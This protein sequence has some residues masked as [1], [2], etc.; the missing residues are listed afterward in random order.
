MMPFLLGNITSS[1]SPRLGSSS[2]RLSR[3]S[4]L[5]PSCSR[6]IPRR[7]C[8][9]SITT[10]AATRRSTIVLAALTTGATRYI[11]LFGLTLVDIFALALVLVDHLSL[12]LSLLVLG[13]DGTLFRGHGFIVATV[14][15]VFV[16]VVVVSD[17]SCSTE[18]RNPQEIP[19]HL[20]EIPAGLILGL[21]SPEEESLA[22]PDSCATLPVCEIVTP[23]LIH[24]PGLVKDIDISIE[25]NICEWLQDAF[26]QPVPLDDDSFWRLS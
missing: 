12:A 26:L 8:L 7:G 22:G 13:Q 6:L 24:H 18:S 11:G 20:E 19:L 4:R 21:V 9:L 5:S 15:W 3:L 14:V 1:P 16:V 10:T 17:I 25:A 2:S 23:A